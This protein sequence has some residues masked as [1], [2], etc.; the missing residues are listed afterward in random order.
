MTEKKAVLNVT[1]AES[2]ADAVRL[3]AATRNVTISSVVE[4]A[5]AERL[6]WFK[7]RADGLAAMD[8][9]Y[10]LYGYPTPEEEAAA[11]VWVDE[12]ERLL[13][14][15]LASQQRESGEQRESGAA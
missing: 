6:K 5:L 10:R 14:E 11:A 1:V 15:M 8:E 12:E 7:I 4:A 2:V 13:A 9:Y 3:E